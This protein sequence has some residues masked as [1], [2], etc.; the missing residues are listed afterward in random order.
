MLLTPQ[1]YLEITVGFKADRAAL[2]ALS[3]LHRRKAA[4]VDEVAVAWCLFPLLGP[5]T[6]EQTLEVKMTGG[7]MTSP[8]R[9]TGPP[10]QLGEGRAFPRWPP[11]V[12]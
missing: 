2:D 1:V 6:A 10:Q 4:Q 5:H 7:A 11:N 3:R 9:V 12:P 8:E